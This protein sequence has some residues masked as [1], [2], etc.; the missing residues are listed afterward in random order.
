M[1]D[2]S[3]RQGIKSPAKAG[4]EADL[5]A[6]GLKELSASAAVSAVVALPQGLLDSL[7]VGNQVEPVTRPLMTGR[8]SSSV[9]PRRLSIS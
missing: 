4:L 5:L 9:T 7:V 6:S 3:A 2:C 1:P 8:T